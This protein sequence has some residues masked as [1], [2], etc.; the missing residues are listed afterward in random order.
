MNNEIDIASWKGTEPY[1]NNILNEV[2]H[3]FAVDYEKQLNTTRARLI[4]LFEKV[5]RIDSERLF[6]P[7]EALLLVQVAKLCDEELGIEEFFTRT[8]YTLEESQEIALRLER[9]AAG[10]IHA[11]AS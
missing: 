7:G 1:L 11:T 8:G 6:T 9:I 5:H 2:I 10:Q 3:G 4:T